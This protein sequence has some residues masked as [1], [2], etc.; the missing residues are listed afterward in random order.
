M[1]QALITGLQVA[2]NEKN[3]ILMVPYLTPEDDIISACEEFIE[4]AKVSKDA[5]A[6]AEAQQ[7]QNADQVS[8]PEVVE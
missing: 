5:R 1:N 2:R 4:A 3:L 6:Q 7:A 8:D